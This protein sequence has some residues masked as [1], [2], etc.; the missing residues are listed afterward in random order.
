MTIATVKPAFPGG[1][2]RAWGISLPLPVLLML[3]ALAIGLG[4]QLP[5]EEVVRRFGL[6]F[7]R[8]LGDI[9]LILL[10]SFLI[11]ASL[12]HRT[13][14]G[15]GR[16][17]S[18]LAPFGAA[19]MI[20]STTGYAALAPL[21]GAYRLSL[22]M[23][24]LA[25]F[26]LLVPAGPLIVSASLGLEDPAIFVLGFVILVPVVIAGELWL[27]LVDGASER[28]TLEAIAKQGGDWFG[29]APFAVLAGLLLAGWL[30]D[31]R[32]LPVI[33]F[34]VQPKG[35]LLMAGVAA[36]IGTPAPFR[37]ECVDSAVRRTTGLLLL[38][39]A[40]SA[41]GG[42]VTS[43]VP[44]ATLLP[45][46]EG[47]QLIGILGLFGLAA[48]LKLLQGS[49]MATFAAVGPLV[50]PVVL[51]LGLPSAV[52][53]YAICI[54]ALIAIVPNDNYYWLVRRDALEGADER[55]AIVRL[56]GASICQGLAGI[57]M[58]LALWG[59]GLLG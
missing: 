36:W 41:F 51:H 15:I 8:S 12:G 43:V 10:P 38:I 35:A 49:I 16:A 52:A 31:V 14:P 21:A 6:G 17:A 40:A 45:S 37:R 54:G 47:S 50:S 20:C 7:G 30:L 4:A 1:A 9:A 19:G 13:M 34:F 2:V 24:A 59:L 22:A 5:P 28:Q 27:R 39:G 18:L 53:V 33:G 58:L 44:V 23:G 56:T 29:F 42:M 26:A 57:T 11:A 48:L 25:G 55:A 3:G 46:G 32:S